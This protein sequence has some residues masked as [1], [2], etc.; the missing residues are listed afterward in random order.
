MSEPT[1]LVPS[2]P[3]EVAAPKMRFRCSVCTKEVGM[4]NVSYE[5]ALDLLNKHG[6]RVGNILICP[7]CVKKKAR[8]F[9]R[10]FES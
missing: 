3:N 10:S 6:W 2:T 5:D 9:I 1:D 7:D 4:Q 8:Q